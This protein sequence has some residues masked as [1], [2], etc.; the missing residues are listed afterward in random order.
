MKSAFSTEKSNITYEFTDIDGTVDS[1]QPINMSH[2]SAE[3]IAVQIAAAGIVTADA[4]IIAEE[5]NDN[6]N[7]FPANDDA[8]AA[9]TFPLAAGVNNEMKRMQNSNARYLR[10]R[11]AHGTNSGGTFSIF[12]FMKHR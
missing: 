6:V 9:L 7:W 10:F 5:S 2:F 11:F 8:G 3:S 1:T 12:V 4:S